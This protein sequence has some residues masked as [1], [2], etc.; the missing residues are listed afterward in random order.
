MMNYAF[1]TMNQHLQQGYKSLPLVVP[2]CFIM[3]R[4]KNYRFSVNWMS[5]FPLASLANK[6]YS[7]SFSLIDLTS[8]DDDILLTHKKSSSNGNC[9]KHVNSCHDINDCNTSIKSNKSRKTC[10][11]E[12]TVLL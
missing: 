5:C 6:L 3:E 10:R 9:N 11:D 8:I 1:Y 2:F 12:D 4:K 7:N